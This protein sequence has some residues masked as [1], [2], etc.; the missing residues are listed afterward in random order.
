LNICSIL[1]KI[2]KDSNAPWGSAASSSNISVPVQVIVES[3]TSEG[4]ITQDIHSIVE[5]RPYLLLNEEDYFVPNGVYCP[6]KNNLKELPKL[7]KSFSF[8]LSEVQPLPAS[9][10][11][12]GTIDTQYV[13]NTLIFGFSFRTALNFGLIIGRV[14]L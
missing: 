10:S 3:K 14:R 9:D 5:F 12:V 8:S 4:L 7:P 13:S 11:K 1:K 6:G 2:C